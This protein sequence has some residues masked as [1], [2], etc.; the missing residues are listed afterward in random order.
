MIARWARAA[1]CIVFGLSGAH[2]AF[3]ADTGA[4]R[5]A[6]LAPH[7]AELVFS[8]GAGARLIA[9][10]SYSDYPEAVQQLPKIG[11][12]FAVD[13]EQ[14]T[15]LGPDLLL[16]WESG[17]PTHVVDELRQRGFRVVTI[18]TQSLADIAEATRTIG[19][20]A[21]TKPQA[22]AA[23]AR[24]TAQVDSLRRRYA[25]SAAIRTFYQ[26]SARPIYTING[27]HF[28][29]EVLALC[30]ADNVF[31]DLSE[32]A[33]VVSE[34]AVLARDPELLLSGNG[35]ASLDPWTRWESLA[36]N[37]HGN[38]FAVTGETIARA[39]LRLAT[40]AADVCETVDVA[41]QKRAGAL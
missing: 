6:T 41:R 5:I 40:A 34:E 11:D 12:A 20:L 3:P 1:A 16:A 9:V 39:S 19:M 25:D 36:A 30:G 38:R 17:T 2:A 26:I 7:L 31:A 32:L 27:K 13:L 21:G 18:R 33:P 15:L 8:A 4:S 10:S 24:Y 28:I 37:R 23:A 14:L 29:S 35:V 22:E